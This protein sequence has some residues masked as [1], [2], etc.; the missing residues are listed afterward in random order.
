MKVIDKIID[1]YFMNKLKSN[2]SDLFIFYG[3]N[4]EYIESKD[5]ITLYIKRE[6]E[7]ITYHREVCNFK[8][9][10]ALEYM[11]DF[12]TTIS[13]YFNGVLEEYKK[14]GDKVK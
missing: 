13:D 6:G 10:R 12:D 7:N 11:L 5:Y 4:T 14:L 9:D 2:I 3:L 8:K 1:K